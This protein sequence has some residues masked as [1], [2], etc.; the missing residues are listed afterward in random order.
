MRVVAWQ[1]QDPSSIPSFDPIRE[2][3][4]LLSNALVL[5]LLTR[6]AYW[7]IFPIQIANT[8]SRRGVLI[9]KAPLKFNSACCCLENRAG[10]N[11][12]E[13]V[14]ACRAKLPNNDDDK[15]KRINIT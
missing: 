15:R 9:A 2:T 11:L 14:N 13:A 3:P 7:N 12:E 6:K 4:R 10:R 5:S 1:S 8:H